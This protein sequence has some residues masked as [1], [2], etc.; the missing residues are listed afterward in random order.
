M[1]TSEPRTHRSVSQG[2]ASLPERLPSRSN[3]RAGLA[4]ADA[5]NARR[6]RHVRDGRQ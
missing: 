1:S 2:K 5:R 4:G 6:A 3:E